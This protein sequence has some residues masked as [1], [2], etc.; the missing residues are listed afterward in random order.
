[1]AEVARAYP[2]VVGQHTSPLRLIPPADLI[3]PPT[4]REWMVEQC[5]PKAQVAMVSGDGGIGKSLLMQQLLTCAV[6]GLPWLGLRTTPG[7]ALFLSCEDDQK[8]I[9]KRQWD[10]CRSLGRTPEDCFEAGLFLA[11]Q[12]GQ[13][14]T[15]SRLD[16]KTWRMVPTEL[17]AVI[18]ATCQKEGVSYVVIDTATQVFA[19]NQNDES[20]VI[21][22]INQLRRLA[23]AIQGIVIITKHPSLSGRAL[24]T[25]ESGNTAWNNSVRSRLY[26]YERKGNDPDHPITELRGM[27]SNYARKLGKMQLRWTRGCFELD[28]PPPVRDWSEPQ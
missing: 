14:N 4:P 6:L 10:I 12:V 17:F 18:L 7:R 26:V 11:D 22:F 25:G 16:R 2:Q 23:I 24:G 20:Q 1:M 28:E 13:E 5:F 27:K 9:H 3:R 19:G 21:Q 8:E 15:L